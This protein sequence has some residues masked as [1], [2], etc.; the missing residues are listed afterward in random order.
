MTENCKMSPRPKLL[1][2]ITKKP[3]VAEV[4]ALR[5]FHFSPSLTCNN[6]VIYL[7]SLIFYIWVCISDSGCN[8]LI[9][10]SLHQLKEH[11]RT[12]HRMSTIECLYD[13]CKNG[14]F[15]SYKS[16]TT[17]LNRKHKGSPYT[18]L[19]NSFKVDTVIYPNE[20][21][22]DDI[23]ADESQD[24]SQLDTDDQVESEDDPK[25]E[26]SQHDNSTLNIQDDSDDSEIDEIDVDDEDVVRD[27]LE[28]FQSFRIDL[29]TDFIQ[30][31]SSYFRPFIISF[32]IFI[33]L[34]PDSL[35][36]FFLCTKK[37]SSW[38]YFVNCCSA[39]I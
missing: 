21:P 10:N 33:S 2:L 22:D 36:N 32:I 20:E 5:F 35:P 31:G 13:N 11:I 14:P 9:F 3:E 12:Y 25:A 1:N 16:F 17:H 37:I 27:D 8:H 7:V 39:A 4:C 38:T 34:Y 6:Y 28:L 19:K 24:N 18:R 30:G 26:E 23:Q 15:Q 29:L